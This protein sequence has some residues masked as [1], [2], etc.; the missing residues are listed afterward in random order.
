[1]VRNFITDNL[2]GRYGCLNLVIFWQ[3]MGQWHCPQLLLNHS[4]DFDKIEWI[5]RLHNGDVTVMKNF[6]LDNLDYI[7]HIGRS[8]ISH[9]FYTIY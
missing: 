2:C 3:Y 1:M 9:N 4:Q 7:L 6:F 8:L 5:A